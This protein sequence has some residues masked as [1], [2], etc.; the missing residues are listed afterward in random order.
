MAEKKKKAIFGKAKSAIGGM[1]AKLGKSIFDITDQAA[2]AAEKGAAEVKKQSQKAKDAIEAKAKE[3]KSG[4]EEIEKHTIVQLGGTKIRILLPDGYERIKYKNPVKNA[5]KVVTNTDAAYGKTVGNSDNIVMIT[6][7]TPERAMNPD[8]VQGLID[9]IHEYLSDKQGIIEVKNGI[10]PRGYQYI[11]SI[12]KTLSE[13]SFGGVRYF[14]RL[15]LFYDSDIIEIQADFT[16]IGT[17][18]SREAICSDLARGA[19]LADIYADGYKDWAKDPYDPDYTKG[20]L[21]NL[22]EKEGLDVLFPESPLSQV[23]EFLLAV[24]NDEFVNVRQEADD[25]EE[26]TA[27]EENDIAE[28]PEER[29]KEFLLDLFV[30]ECRRCTFSIEVEKKMDDSASAEKQKKA[31]PEDTENPEKKTRD[32]LD[33]QLKNAVTAYNAEYTKLNNHGMALFNQRERALDLLGNIENLINSIANHPK[34][35]DADL[36]EI[37]IKKQEFKDVCDF[38]KEELSAAQKSAVGT[39]VGVAGGMAVASVAPTAAMWIATTFGTASTGTA[40]SSLSGA[41][42]TKAALAWIGGGALSAGGGGMAAGQAFL[43]MTGPIGWS[44]AGATLLTSIALFANKK[45]KMDKD[46]KEEIDAV[47]N[48]T[49]QLKEANAKLESLLKKTVEIRE[50]LS[51]KYTQAMR[52]FGRNILDISR[53]DRLLL[54][55]IVDNA[56]AL[57]ASLRE[58]I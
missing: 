5:A 42:A 52:C 19:G 49:E 7:S 24:L 57:A 50:N 30:D 28:S 26:I 41:A 14:L 45:I 2:S 22:A 48:N 3:A 25:A 1:G 36:A 27:Q 6:K 53:E 35:F 46:K 43:A 34:K 9:V 47:L 18:G 38:A 40:I 11:Y 8:D 44:I 39:G 12:V 51:G 33:D 31:E 55:T 4:N 23:H 54:G 21:K 29:E 56:K 13:E 37:Q 17:I 10:T 20:C 16:E 15:N 32:K 58:G